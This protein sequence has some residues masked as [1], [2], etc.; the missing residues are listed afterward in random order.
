MIPPSLKRPSMVPTGEAWNTA[1]NR[2]SL[3]RTFSSACFWSVMLSSTAT[4]SPVA[5]R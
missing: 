5:G 1:W 4:N 3:A 2:A